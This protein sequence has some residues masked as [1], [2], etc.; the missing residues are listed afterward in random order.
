MVGVWPG[1]KVVVGAV[2]VGTAPANCSSSKEGASEL[3][4]ALST[5]QPPNRAMR[6]TKATPSRRPGPAAVGVPGG[7]GV[8]GPRP[9]RRWVGGGAGRAS[10]SDGPTGPSESGPIG[11]GAAAGSMG[12]RSSSAR[13]PGPVT[14][15]GQVGWLR[16]RTGPGDPAG[17][18]AGSSASRSRASANCRAVGRRAGSLAMAHSMAAHTP[19]G[20]PVGRRSSTAS[21]SMVAARA[22]RLLPST[23]STNG[24]RPVTR[25]NRVAPRA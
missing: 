11:P 16:P 10:A 8:G 18:A 23:R 17:S 13:P 22:T 24:A 20:T 19:S 2:V 7:V 5:E 15:V 14:G 1:P 12:I 3:R 9:V 4:D 21:A 25:W 6:T